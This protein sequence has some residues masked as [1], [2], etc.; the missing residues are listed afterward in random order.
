[1]IEKTPNSVVIPFD[2]IEVEFAVCPHEMFEMDF[3]AKGHYL[4]YVV[5]VPGPFENETRSET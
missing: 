5:R 2:D 1:M 4:V 3:V